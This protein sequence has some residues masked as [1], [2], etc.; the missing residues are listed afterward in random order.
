ME[1]YEWIFD[2]VGTTLI[3]II[4]SFVGYKAAVKKVGKQYQLSGD[5]S[6]QMQEIHIETSEEKGESV[7]KQVQEGGN[8]SEQV[9]IGRFNNKK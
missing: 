4:C 7:F 1:W 8:N 3:G 6:K 2:G 5:N 9:Q